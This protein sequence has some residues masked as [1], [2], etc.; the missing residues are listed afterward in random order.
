[1]DAGDDILK[2]S[3]EGGVQDTAAFQKPDDYGHSALP[4]FPCE[5]LRCFQSR[6]PSWMRHGGSGCGQGV[7][8]Q[9]TDHLSKV[10]H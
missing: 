1:M 6:T 8:R 10:Q 2:H 4:T 9:I 5:G 7:Q 3:N